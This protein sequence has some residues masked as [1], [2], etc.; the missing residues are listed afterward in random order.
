MDMDQLK[1]SSIPHIMYQEHYLHVNRRM[2]QKYLNQNRLEFMQAQLDK[3]KLP[4]IPSWEM[5][6]P[7]RTQYQALSLKED[8]LEEEYHS[9]YCLLS[10]ELDS[11]FKTPML[12]AAHECWQM[13]QAAWRL[14]G[15]ICFKCT[16]AEGACPKGI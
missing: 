3:L 16:R 1:P 6:Q 11:R 2:L 8:I 14:R 4:S 12:R 9:M 10:A 7:D 15:V 5:D 13:D